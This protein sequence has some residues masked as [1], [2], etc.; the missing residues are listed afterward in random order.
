MYRTSLFE[1]VLSVS[2]KSVWVKKGTM[3]WWRDWKPHKWM[4]VHFALEQYSGPEG[5]KDGILFIYY[6]FHEEK[7]VCLCISWCILLCFTFLTYTN[8]IVL[9]IFCFLSFLLC[10]HYV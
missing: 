1:H 8:L 6:N 10:C 4:D 5:N 2:T 9:I 7:K 3:Q